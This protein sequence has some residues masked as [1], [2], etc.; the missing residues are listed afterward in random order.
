[1]ALIVPI[2]HHGQRGVVRTPLP[3]TI[4][5][6]SAVSEA[7]AAA[8]TIATTS[9]RVDVAT[10]SVSS[11]VIRAAAVHLPQRCRHRDRQTG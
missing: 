11:I 4:G 7:I 3:K 9:T 5:T 2:V 1:M 10:H 6:I 8:T